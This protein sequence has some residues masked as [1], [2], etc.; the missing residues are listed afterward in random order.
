[1]I[2]KFIQMPAFGLQTLS[3]IIYTALL[4]SLLTALYCWTAAMRSR[5]D[6]LSLDVCLTTDHKPPPLAD[7][8]AIP[9]RHSV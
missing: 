6:A 7:C 5:F 3:S 2:L 9:G 4:A 1:M 8:D